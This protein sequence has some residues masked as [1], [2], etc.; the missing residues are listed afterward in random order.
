MKE[1]FSKEKW[2]HLFYTVSHP[3]DGYYWIRHK[4]KGSVAIAFLLV[5]VFGL[6]FSMN[7]LYASF[8]VSDVNVRS[9]NLLPEI[10][11]VLMMYI[12]LSVGNWSITCLMD[13]EGR[14]KDILIAVGYAMLPMIVTYI[15]ATIVSQFVAEN[16]EAFYTIIMFIGIAYTLIMML[17]GI[18]QVHNYTLGK[19]LLTLLL[20][21]VAVLIIIFLVLLIT[22]FIGQVVAFLESIYTELIFRM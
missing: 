21:I 2:S 6:C 4:E 17:T 14:F 11:G 8:V 18:M 7:R 16:E 22:N 1:L 9:V 12:L 10:A 5:F 3:S 15:L 20:T 13:G 19:T